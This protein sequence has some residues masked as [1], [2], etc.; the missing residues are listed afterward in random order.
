MKTTTKRVASL[1]LALLMLLPLA[2]Q[3][4]SCGG[5]GEGTET[6]SG[7]GSETTSDDTSGTDSYTIQLKTVGGMALT[8]VMVYVVNEE[9]NLIGSA[10]SSTDENG[11]VT[12]A[13]PKGQKYQAELTGVP[14]GYDVKDRYDLTV[15]VNTI[16]LKSEVI[17]DTDLSGVIY[18]PG[19]IMHDFE[20][21]TSDGEIFKLSE[22]LKEKKAVMLNFW[23]TTCSWC[24]EE[25]P[26]MNTVYN[27]YKDKIEIIAINNYSSD[28]A[29]DVANF[30]ANYYDFP[31]DFPMAKDTAGIE[32]AFDVPGNPVS[33]IVDRYGMIALYYPGA[34]NESQFRKIFS[35]FSAD[36]YKQQIYTSL[37]DL[38]PKDKPDIEMAPSA[39]FEAALNVGNIRVTYTPELEAADKEYSWPFE[40]TEKNGETCVA[41]T[42]SGK[43]GHFATLHAKVTLKAGEA[44]VFDY[45][46]SSEAGADI[47]YV[48]VNGKDIYQIS[49]EETEWKENCPWVAIEDGEYDV[50]FVYYKNNSGMSGDDKVYLKDFRVVPKDEVKAAS[51]IPR[52]AATG[53]TE[54]KSDYTNYVSV[55]YSEVDGYYHVGTA[56]GPILLAKLIFGSNFSDTSV[57]EK[58]IDLGDTFMVDGKNCFDQF[59]KYCTYA[60]NSKIY[61]YCSVTKDLRT[62]LE[63]YVEQFGLN[64]HEDT[65][66]RLCYYYD[67][68]GLEED[69]TPVAQ[70]E[71]PIKGLSSHSAYT[72][73]EGQWSADN[74]INKVE[75][76][77]LA[78]IPRGYLYEFIPEKSGV[79]RFTTTNTKLE[80]IGWIFSGNDAE[81]IANGDRIL[82]TDSDQGE[83]FCRELLIE[84][85][86][87]DENGNTKTELVLDTLNSSM[88][89]YM[90]AGTPY[91]VD[92]AYYEPTASGSFNF[93]VVYLGEK[94][95]YFISASAGPF[96]FELNDDGTQGDTIAVAIDVMKGSDGYYYHK[97]ADG[98]QG[99]LIYA[100][101]YM[102]TSVFTSNTLKDMIE[103]G[104]YN[105]TLSELDH[106]AIAAW[107]SAGKD[108]D[109]LREKW[110]AEA[111]SLW[112]HYQMDDIIKGK[113]HG[114]G[115]DMT[116][117]A[118]TYLDKIIDDV[119]QDNAELQGCVPVD[120]QLMK[121]LWKLMDKY[122]FAGVENSWCKLCY[123]YDYLGQ[124]N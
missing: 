94:Y 79:Y 38:V 28:S 20:L 61:M 23:Y 109:K 74:D 25:F 108:E 56:D 60:N 105:F 117:I 43:D 69:G 81:W 47:L 3:M 123:Y 8:D 53:L 33:V 106:E 84:K 110:G 42:N 99:S 12:Y 118:R 46:A 73:V 78:M 40:V 29:A 100:D 4:V 27:E 7:S 104:A 16:I 116:E 120:E 26:G 54:D 17:A 98:T 107:E 49:G 36:D 115:E 114:T 14:D 39:D 50:A 57:T 95:D 91:Y 13:L 51:Y 22:V 72:A 64:P 86:T 87:T 71:D 112:A 82:Y 11:M 32:D 96:S 85:T 76:N 9:G 119:T 88:V 55:V 102:T 59:Y 75:Y 111:D 65:W 35:V 89:A 80:T 70:F 67:V 62:Y 113:Y 66:L 34:I 83:R 19:M 103:K 58:L 52:N 63:A 48:L 31:L 92:F 122:T 30:K 5:G 24:V 37:D 45:L 101:F 68:Y 18:E 10:R 21:T 41:P 1:L 121:L 2:F 15:G 97:K 6:E 124:N 44:F 93:S 90:E 77:G